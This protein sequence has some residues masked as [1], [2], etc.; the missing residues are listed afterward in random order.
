M[1][2]A[3]FDENKY[4][5]A[6]G[7]DCFWI[8]GLLLSEASAAALEKRLRAIQTDFFGT[9]LLAPSSELHGKELFH[10]KGNCKG[11]G[12]DERMAVFERVADCVVELKLAMQFVCINVPR[13]RQKYKHPVDE[14]PLGLMLALERYDEFLGAQNASGLVFC[15]HEA[16]EISRAMADFSTFKQT[17]STRYWKGR[18]LERIHDTIYFTPSHHSRFMQAADLLVYLAARFDL[19]KAEPERWHEARAWSAWQ[20]IKASAAIQHWP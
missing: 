9:S 19:V 7:R 10:G 13:H 12:L 5:P 1:W 14:Y 16:D 11:R 18:S 17:G 15:D 20:K 3:Y 2:L 4:D 6:A 8:G